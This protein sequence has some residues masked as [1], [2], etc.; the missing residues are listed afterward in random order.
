MFSWKISLTL[1]PTSLGLTTW[2]LQQIEW[3]LNF[4]S[5]PRWLRSSC[6]GQ[7]GPVRR[8]NY[9]GHCEIWEP[10]HLRADHLHNW[11]ICV[12]W[13][14]GW[15]IEYCR[16]TAKLP[17]KLDFKICFLNILKDHH[18]KARY[19]TQVYKNSSLHQL[20]FVDTLN[21]L[22]HLTFQWSFCLLC[23]I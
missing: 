7:A 17:L 18:F 4:R 20:Q 15:R 3:F 21:G 8:R 19:D 11:I 13:C 6:E 10:R 9:A 5:F 2:H 16:P 1:A 22:T 12:G 23:S 14:L